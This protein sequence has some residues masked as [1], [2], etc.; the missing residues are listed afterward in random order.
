MP[1]GYKKI[2][3]ANDQT[4]ND[5]IIIKNCDFKNLY[6]GIGSHYYSY[7]KKTKAQIYHNDVLVD[8]CEFINMKKFGVQALN[9]SNSKIT[10]CQFDKVAGGKGD[11]CGIMGRGTQKLDCINNSFKNIVDSGED[12]GFG[13]KVVDYELGNSNAPRTYPTFVKGSAEKENEY[14]EGANT[15][16]NVSVKSECKIILKKE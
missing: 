3:A 16:E 4:Y 12:K 8:G 7:N 14:F 2:W 10:N 15:F 9:W 13:F 1:D 11:V 6:V 5:H